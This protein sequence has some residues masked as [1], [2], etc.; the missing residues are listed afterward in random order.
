MKNKVPVIAA[1]VLYILLSS[2]LA[3]STIPAKAGANSAIATVNGHPVTQDMLDDKVEQ[4]YPSTTAHGRP[5]GP[6]EVRQ[7]AF[8]QVVLD[9]LIWQEAVRNHTVTSWKAAHKEMLRVRRQCGARDFDAGLSAKGISRLQ[10][11]K[12]L[13]RSMTINQ[14]IK[15]HIDD[16]AKVTPADARSFFE[17]NR[18]RFHRPDRVR[19]RLI[20]VAVPE[21]A[22]PQ[23]EAAAQ[24]KAEGFY[25]Q[26][27]NG[28]DF[29]E[30]AYEVSEDEY[31]WKGGD[32]GWMH[33]GS[34]DPDFEPL[35]FSLPI[36]QITPP[37]RTPPGYSI[38]RV[39]AREPAKD[40]SYDEVRDM[41]IR[42]L[43]IQKTKQ[44]QQKWETVLKQNARVEVL[45]K[46][47]GLQLTTS[48]AFSKL[49]MVASH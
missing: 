18:S 32:V 1:L 42:E 22:S 24:K 2:S 6:A 8:D 3:A 30:L 45:D 35:A 5:G 47:N 41:L 11:T 7:K 28:K 39:E 20:L 49:S 37:F 9:E 44:L 43:G 36:G 34:L 29:E 13:Q 26:L 19:M 4:L 48:S 38:M 23:E 25:Q 31:K 14:A 12:M 46:A 27:K 17:A 15:Q 10:Y 33:K 21:K 40:L 16:R